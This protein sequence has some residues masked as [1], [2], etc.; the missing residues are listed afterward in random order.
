[1]APVIQA[2]GRRSE[3]VRSIVCSTGQHREMLERTLALFAITPD[4]DL[5]LMQHNQGLA[6]L[7]ARL[8]VAL[9]RLLDK[10]RPDCVLAQGDTTTVLASHPGARGP[11]WKAMPSWWGWPTKNTRDRATSYLPALLYERLDELG[12]D[13][14]ILYP[15]MALGY[16][17]VTG[18]D[19]GKRYRIRFGCQLNVE[20]LDHRGRR[21]RVLCFLPEGSVPAGDV[22]LAQ[23][24]AL[25][26]F[27]TDAIKVAHKSPTWDDVLGVQVRRA[28]R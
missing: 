20:E 23:K 10:A 9:D 24:V 19:T 7:T 2:L 15:S 21:V 5:R 8:I 3:Q 28:R 22:M 17:E 1:M 18:C 27:E 6:A 11:G 12:I 25:E 4:Y 14:T 16:F 13:F 26:L